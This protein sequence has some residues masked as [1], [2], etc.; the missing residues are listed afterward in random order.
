MLPHPRRSLG[1]SD[2]EYRQ[3]LQLRIARAERQDLGP[4]EKR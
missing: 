4:A 3:V 1:I 2:L